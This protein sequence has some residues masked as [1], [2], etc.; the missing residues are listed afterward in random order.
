VYAALRQVLGRHRCADLHDAQRLG[1]LQQA[2]G[3]ALAAR[4]RQ[5]TRRRTSTPVVTLV[6][7]LIRQRPDV[8]GGRAMPSV[9][10]LPIA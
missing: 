2:L 8:D 7:G 6:V 3:R 10:L 4:Y 1:R 9:P 5:R